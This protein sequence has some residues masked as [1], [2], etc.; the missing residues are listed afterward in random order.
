MLFLTLTQQKDSLINDQEKL[1]KTY[2]IY[3]IFLKHN[4]RESS[5]NL[6]H[7]F[8]NYENSLTIKIKHDDRYL[9]KNCL[10][11]TSHSE[12][13]IHELPL[14]SFSKRVLEL[15]HMKLA[16]HMQIKNLSSLERLAPKLALKKKPKVI[17]KWPILNG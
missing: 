12:K 9:S 2:P 3:S 1:E 16:N 17:R 6:M 11:N 10:K 5:Q 8:I 7:L 13:A 4:P 14:A 15:I